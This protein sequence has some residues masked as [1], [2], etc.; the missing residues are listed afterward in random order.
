MLK[1]LQGD[2]GLFGPPGV[3]GKECQEE[4]FSTGILI[5]RHSQT[6]LVP[7]CPRG[8]TR[9]WDG[10]SLLYVEGNERSHHQD[11]G[12][13]E[14]HSVNWCALPAGI[15]DKDSLK[16]ILKNADIIKWETSVIIQIV[17]FNLFELFW[18]K[19]GVE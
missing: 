14:V 15:P 2:R 8:Q 13:C 17:L 12:G 5:V 4:R 1:S 7:Q 11:L 10:Y 9:L 18:V 3:P 16:H 6:S 19:H